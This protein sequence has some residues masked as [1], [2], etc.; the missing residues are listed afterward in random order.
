MKKAISSGRSIKVWPEED[1]PRE[2]LFKNGPGALSN[3]EL[4]AILLRTG[5]NGISAIDLARRVLQKFV[6]FRN[7]AQTDSRDWQAFKGLGK[8]KI[9]Q[10]KAA[11]E[12]A[13]RFSI[14]ESRGL[15]QSFVYSEE[16]VKQFKEYMLSRK[17]EQVKVLLCDP[18]NRLIEAVDVAYGT[19]TECHPLIREIISQALQKFAAGLVCLHNHPCGG[20]APSRE[21]EF[22]P[23]ISSRQRRLWEFVFSII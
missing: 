10:I 4:L 23:L 17:V 1:R 3:S 14:Q 16:I 5:T 7:M 18:K 9:A 15:R 21:D 8:A 20:S 22:L 12:I 19:P 6:T 2:K 11:L 13:N